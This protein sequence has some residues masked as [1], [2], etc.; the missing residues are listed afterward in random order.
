[1]MNK[2]LIMLFL[3]FSTAIIAQVDSVRVTWVDP[4]LPSAQMLYIYGDTTASTTTLRDSINLATEDW[5]WQ[6]P[7]AGLWHFRMRARTAGYVYSSYSNEDTVTIGG[8]TNS[9]HLTNNLVYYWDDTSGVDLGEIDGGA[10]TNWWYPIVGDTVL[11][12]FD[13]DNFPLVTDSGVVAD[14]NDFLYTP[15]NTHGITVGDSITLEMVIQLPDTSSNGL[16]FSIRDAANTVHA[17]GT[18][19]GHLTGSTFA[20]AEFFT[21]THFR[22]SFANRMLH[23]I[24]TFN[25]T[26]GYLY[27]NGVLMTEHEDYFGPYGSSNRI[28]IG[29]S[30]NIN[31]LVY[32]LFRIYNNYVFD[33]ADVDQNLNSPSV[34]AKG[35]E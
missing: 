32:R 31:N 22:T 25:G 24:Y 21:G 8:G 5:Y 16:I 26:Q 27:I 29:Q 28:E 18:Q 1:M 4:T 33:I 7:Y 14:S 34:Q 9:S 10:G 3:I 19:N 12:G 30:T 17:I 20:G 13:V 23:I 11:R 6:P 2:L 35:I 15:T